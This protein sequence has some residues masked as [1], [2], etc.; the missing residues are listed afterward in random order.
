M[1]LR[2]ADAIREIGATAGLQVHRSHWVADAQVEKLKRDNGKLFVV[3]KDGSE[4]PV[5]R[6]FQSAARERYAGR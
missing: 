6:T 3:T 4:I 1:L 2:F 5:S